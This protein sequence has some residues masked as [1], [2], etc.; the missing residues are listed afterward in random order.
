MVRGSRRR[1]A[2][3]F[4]TTSFPWQRRHPLPPP[5]TRA[6]Q[7]PRIILRSEIGLY[8]IGR[9][10]PDRDGWVEVVGKHPRRQAIQRPRR[11]VPVD[12]RGRY[13][14]CF[15]WSHRAAVC[16][17]RTRCFRCL[18]AG[19]R[20]FCCPRSSMSSK[21]PPHR[22]QASG[23]QW[24]PVQATIANM[25][26][27]AANSGKE[28]PRRRARRRRRRSGRRAG[29]GS[30]PQSTPEGSCQSD[31]GPG[32]DFSDD[33]ASCVAVAAARPV[34][35][36]D[37][38]ARL[39]SAKAE[40]RRA[41]VVTIGGN[42]PTLEA[43]HVLQEVARGFEIDV[44]SMQIMPFK[45]E[46]FLLLLPDWSV[47]ERVYNGG[48]PFHGPGFILIFKRWSTFAH[49]DAALPPVYVEGEITGV[50]AHAWELATAQQLLGRSCWVQPLHPDMAARRDMTS[51]HFSAWRL[52]DRVR[53]SR[54]R[55]DHPGAKRPRV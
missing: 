9:G 19:H 30:L 47:A 3:R 36:I 26:C 24:R 5:P 39:E 25:A 7:A 2:H 31:G 50:P 34:C 55:L 21:P 22:P 12:L 8:V 53:P 4:V 15:A 1:P 48:L 46:D 44:E 20:A 49:A 38:T 23:M 29:D 27:S 17:R 51:L 41:L 42:H 14:N 54:C 52:G 10:K 43:G 18:E 45:P 32:V 33:S 13:F 40:L 37:R 28:P 16:R 6:V 35:I 11:E